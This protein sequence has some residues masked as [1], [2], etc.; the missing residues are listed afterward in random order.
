MM[1]GGTPRKADRV[2]HD[3]LARIVKGQIAVGSVLPTE[4]ELA[5]AHGVN[6]SVI[7]EAI[8]LLEV[9]HLV[10]PVRRKGTVV[11]DPLASLSPEVLGV[12]L[13]PAPDR[14]DRHVL[15]GLL[16]IRAALDV[17]MIGL[18]AERR[19]DADLAAMK[20]KLAELR[21]ALP[22]PEAYARAVGEL[23]RLTAQATQ[24]PVFVMLAAWH[25]RVSRELGTLFQLVRP[26][27]PA[28]LEGLTLI[29]RLIRDRDAVRA[30]ELARSFHE[31]STP[32]LLAAAALASGESPET[33]SKEV[34]R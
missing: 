2:A 8:K 16:E 3:L 30:R 18:A 29:V 20:D 19:T 11:L 33:I 9:H 28:H 17:M 26:A 7:R 13:Q 23:G 12:M 27:T 31:W 5:A 6:R 10:R 32:R 1:N 14:I 22:D 15:A 24:N 34:R 4:A 25:G 21:R